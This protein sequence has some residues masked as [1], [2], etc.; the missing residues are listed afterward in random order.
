MEEQPEAGGSEV[1]PPTPAPED[2]VPEANENLETTLPIP[3]F[4]FFWVDPPVQ[5]EQ[6]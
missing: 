3:A 6:E 4:D 2:A 1:R 5:H